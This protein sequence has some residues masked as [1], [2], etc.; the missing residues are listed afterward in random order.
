MGVSGSS[1]K[2]RPGQ[3]TSHLA[4]N[5][6]K[7][8]RVCAVWVNSE[9]GDGVRRGDRTRPRREKELEATESPESEFLGA[10]A[11]PSSLLP[12]ETRPPGEESNSVPPNSPLPPSPRH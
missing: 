2:Y 12:R 10:G 11:A 7:A 8:G 3:W 1:T 4:V 6:R 9:K 5:V